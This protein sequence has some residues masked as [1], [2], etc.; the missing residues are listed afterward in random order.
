VGSLLTRGPSQSAGAGLGV[1]GSTRCCGPANWPGQV[2]HQLPCRAAS[3]FGWAPARL[4]RCLRARQKGRNNPGQPGRQPGPPLL[5]RFSLPPSRLAYARRGWPEKLTENHWLQPTTWPT[6]QPMTG[7]HLSPRRGT[8]C[9]IQLNTNG[10]H[11]IPSAAACLSRQRLARSR[12]DPP[13]RPAPGPRT[14]SRMA[15]GPR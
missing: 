13:V 11:G 8:W 7:E 6:A 12:R 4:T 5:S 10:A 9:G 1:T 3:V 2:M 14:G 15:P